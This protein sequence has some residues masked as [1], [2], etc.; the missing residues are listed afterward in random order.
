MKTLT[1]VLILSALFLSSTLAQPP[2]NDQAR[3]LAGLP[4]R[5]P[6][7][8]ALN[9]EPASREHTEFMNKA[10]AQKEQNSLRPI[11][12][13]AGGSAR[14]LLQHT[15]PV[16]YFF[17]GP[18]FLY[19]Q[20]FAPNASTYILCGTEPIGS[21]PD[22]SAIPHEALS[23]S[24][25]ELRKSMGTMLNFHYFI[26]KEMRTDLQGGQLGGT[27]PILYVF[28]ARRGGSIDQV[29][30]VKSPAQGVKIDFHGASGRAQTLYYFK[31]DL[32]NG[33]SGAFLRWCAAQGQG[34]S[35][36]K[37][38]SYLPHS[39]R[40]SQS[41]Q[42]LLDNSRLILQDDSGIPLRSFD[43]RWSLRYF[44]SYR[45]PIE[46]FAKNAQPDLLAAYQQNHPKP[47]NFAFGYHW[48]R[49]QSML[50]LATR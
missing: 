50:M 40:F 12:D 9:R 26:T 43:S 44:G 41:R 13:W 19:A 7:L 10:W 8:E 23:A 11:R 15:G 4:V 33:S 39:D 42:F 24:L 31:T 48:Q 25:G 34:L 32:S 27:L 49:E 6:E 1:S 38:A 28:V 16:Y 3:F 37:A 30:F 21:M 35:L 29:S 5:S 18:D 20:T 46:L 36:L 22:V 45:A 2:P 17:S 14:E 47:L